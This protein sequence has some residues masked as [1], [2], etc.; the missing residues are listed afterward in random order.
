MR[1]LA[2][3]FQALEGATADDDGSLLFSDLRGGGVRRL[4][5]GGRVEVVVPHR[6]AVGG[7]CLHA[8]GGLVVSGAD[9][10]H[11]TP[12][13]HRVLLALDDVAE[14]PGTVAVAFNDIAAD[15]GGRLFAGVLRHDLAGDPVPGELVMVTAER[16]HVVVHDELH[17]NGIG[18]APDGERLYVSDTFGRR[19][20]VLSLRGGSDLPVTLGSISTT[21]VDGLPDGLAVDADE[22]IWVAFYR[23]ACVAR[24]APDGRL[25]R[26]VPVPA[27]KPLSVC[28]TDGTSPELYVVTATREPGSAETGSIYRAPVDVRPAPVHRVRV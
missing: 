18:V 7:V 5:A 25:L 22:C 11:V 26:R 8:D 9:L 6:T 16:R 27:L 12:A 15:P 19:L 24:F 20:I 14:R 28:I 23:G 4:T 2:S 3:G 17:P 21:A 1:L 10:S 13:G